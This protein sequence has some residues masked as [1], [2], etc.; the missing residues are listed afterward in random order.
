MHQNRQYTD[1]NIPSSKK[2]GSESSVRTQGGISRDIIRVALAKPS[3][4]LAGPWEMCW[5]EKKYQR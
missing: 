1:S 3:L 5:I 2:R 4:A